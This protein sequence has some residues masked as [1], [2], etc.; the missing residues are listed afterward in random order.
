MKRHCIALF[1]SLIILT[2]SGCTDDI[3]VKVSNPADA[4]ELIENYITHSSD[5]QLFTIEE[6]GYDEVFIYYRD[7]VTDVLYLNYA[8]GY[9]GGL[10]TMEDPETGLPLTYTR[11]M[12]LASKSIGFSLCPN[13]SGPLT[14]EYCGNCNTKETGE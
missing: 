4:A 2:F 11:Y 12:E 13:C 5:E 8:A 9:K 10:T 14:E 1:L 7:T 3:E 6:V